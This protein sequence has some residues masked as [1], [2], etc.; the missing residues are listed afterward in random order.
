MEAAAATVDR[1]VPATRRVLV[2]DD[3]RVWCEA[4]AYGLDGRHGVACVGVAHSLAEAR[5]RL[6]STSVDGALVD[7]RL[8]DGSGL[9]LIEPLIAADP[10]CRVVMISAHPRADLLRAAQALGAVGLLA[11][12]VSL[13][14]VVAALRAGPVARQRWEDRVAPQPRLTGREHE[15]LGLLATGLDVRGVAR[16]L[17]L[18]VYTVRD[19]VQALLA[20]LGAHS[21]LEAILNAARLGLVDIGRR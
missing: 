20:K 14:A 1:A 21:Q 8:P 6:A 10:Q 9:E 18:S 13:T 7:V 12:E 5:T 4:L 17:D 11:K 19:H 16:R 2:V 15:V 3:H